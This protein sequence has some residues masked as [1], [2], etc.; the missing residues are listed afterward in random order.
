[1]HSIAEHEYTHLITS[2]VDVK[3]LRKYVKNCV[4]AIPQRSYLTV[5]HLYN[6]TINSH[7]GEL[8]VRRYAGRSVDPV[9]QMRHDLSFM[10]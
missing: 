2:V 9:Y 3:T 5:S 1:M 8:Q 10:I 4:S 7:A 6:L